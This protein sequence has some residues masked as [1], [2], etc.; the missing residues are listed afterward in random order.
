MVSAD[1][2]HPA[3]LDDRDHVG[4]LN[5]WEAVGDHDTCATLAGTIQS[6]LDNLKADM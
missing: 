2:R 1:L 6:F 3:T 5:G 4:V